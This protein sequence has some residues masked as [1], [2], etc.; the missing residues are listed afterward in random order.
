[1]TTN[2]DYLP[3][4]MQSAACR[5]IEDGE[6]S[7][8]FLI[9]V[10]SNNLVK[11]AGRADTVN[12]LALFVWAIWMYNEIPSIAWGSKERVYEYAAKQRIRRAEIQGAEEGSSDVR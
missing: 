4:H 10:L 3:I 1:M 8:D 2:Y 9:A 5:Y 11:A 7:D 12:Q 6:I